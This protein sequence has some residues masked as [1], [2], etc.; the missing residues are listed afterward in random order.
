M[1]KE[2]KMG[3]LTEEAR[4]YGEIANKK[5][6]EISL[7]KRKAIV[8]LLISIVMILFS[9]IYFF[10]KDYSELTRI[11]EAEFSRISR[12]I[13]MMEWSCEEYELRELREYV[14]KDATG[15]VK[16]CYEDGSVALYLDGKAYT[17]KIK[18]HFEDGKMAAD[19]NQEL[20]LHYTVSERKIGEV[21][22]FEIAGRTI[23]L[24]PVK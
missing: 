2:L 4:A 24:Y 20:Y 8:F 18:F 13:D 1:S 6:M 7:K 15:L 14:F 11:S 16:S 21:L 5:I 12:Y 10:F 9:Y 19:S 3:Q 23:I 22:F 17:Q